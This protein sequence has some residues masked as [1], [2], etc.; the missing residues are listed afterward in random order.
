VF[1]ATEHSESVIG[2]APIRNS[3]MEPLFTV[4]AHG[5][6][7]GTMVSVFASVRK[8]KAVCDPSCL[9]HFPFSLIC[10]SWKMGPGTML[11]VAP[12]QRPAGACPGPRSIVKCQPTPLRPETLLFRPSQ[13]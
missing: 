10:Q 1:S 11:A 5:H 3:S 12:L 13:A 2:N 9:A 8:A 6:V 4:I 7:D